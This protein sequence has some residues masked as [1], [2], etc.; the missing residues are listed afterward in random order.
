MAQPT[1]VEE[2][3]DRVQS[4]FGS[5]QEELERLQKELG[6]RR[7]SFEKEAQKRVR[8]LR[9]E[10]RKNGLVK[11]AESFQK[12]AARRLETGV[13][14]VLSTFQIASQGDLKRID[15]KLGQI[16]RKLTALEKDQKEEASD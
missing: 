1:F 9:S 10:L 16:S 5:V 6:K 15:R 4:A 14:S 13:E 12:D 7:R 11:R 3:L 8:Q 2:G